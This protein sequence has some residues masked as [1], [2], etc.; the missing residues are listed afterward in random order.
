[1]RGPIGTGGFVE[2]SPR[3][4]VCPT[5][6][7]K[8]FRIFS[9]PRYRLTVLAVVSISPWLLLA[10]CSN[11]QF[12]LSRACFTLTWSLLRYVIHAVAST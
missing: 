8:R 3:T 10:R 7:C 11:R 12:D 1:M 6:D 2:L 9:V 4:R 5:I